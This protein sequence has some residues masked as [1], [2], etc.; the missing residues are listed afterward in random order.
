M[1]REDWNAAVHGV[2]LETTEKLN[3]TRKSENQGDSMDLR[4]KSSVISWL[5][6]A[7]KNPTDCRINHL[8]SSWQDIEQSNRGLIHNQHTLVKI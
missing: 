8:W 6:L 4:S 3:W 1:D 7:L 5:Q 2:E